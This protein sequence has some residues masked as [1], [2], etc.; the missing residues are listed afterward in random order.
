MADLLPIDLPFE[1]AI[2]FFVKK[3]LQLSPDSWR[4]LWREAN[5]R[6][7]TVAQVT[8]RAILEDI[9]KLVDQAINSGMSI[10]EF[11]KELR[12][13][14][15]RKGWFAPKG[16]PPK[17]ELPDGTIRKRLTPW[18]LDNI[19]RTNLQS[20]YSAGRYKQMEEVGRHRPYWQYRAIMDSRT[21]PAHAAMNN[22]VYDYRHPIWDKWYPPNGFGCRCYVKSISRNQLEQR[23]LEPSIDPP[24]VDP[25]EGW[26][27]NVGKEGLRDWN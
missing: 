16:E 8:D 6:A 14:L 22:K 10:Q 21:R 23:D 9:K 26:N 19:Y 11:K 17:V 4:D 3:G 5:A 1:E 24:T 13:Q 27:Y 2:A 7:F 20:A 15:Q 18:R 25:D 12:S